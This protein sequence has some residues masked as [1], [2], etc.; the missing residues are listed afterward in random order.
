MPPRPRT[1][2]TQNII[3]IRNP[4]FAKNEIYSK[5]W[6]DNAQRNGPKALKKNVLGVLTENRIFTVKFYIIK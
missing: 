2:H 3:K 6:D 4:N 5:S 1:F